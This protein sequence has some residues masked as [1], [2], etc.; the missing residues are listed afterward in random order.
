MAT[1]LV[2]DDHDGFRSFARTYLAANGFQVI[3]EAKDGETALVEIR[4]LRPDIVLLDIQLP[5]VDGFDVS[6]RVAVEPDPPAVVLIS[7]RDAAD[8]GPSVATSG[9][10]GFLPKAGLTGAAIR[11][12]VG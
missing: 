6:R 7:S 12:L 5:D 3:G 11:E 10:R 9:A 2:V 8:Y 1:V 4:R